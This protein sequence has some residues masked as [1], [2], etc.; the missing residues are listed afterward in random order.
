MGLR[1]TFGR[2]TARQPQQLS[3]NVVKWNPICKDWID[4]DKH[5]SVGLS[6]IQFRST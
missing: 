3:R 4:A 2:P 5:Y 6:A 1:P